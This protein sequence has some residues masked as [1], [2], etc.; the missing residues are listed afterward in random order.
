MWPLGFV[1]LFHFIKFR[2]LNF[3]SLNATW[4]LTGFLQLSFDLVAEALR[5]RH[6]AVM[7]SIDYTSLPTTT[8]LMAFCLEE[9]AYHGKVIKELEL[10]F[11]LSDSQ[12]FSTA[13][14]GTPF[15]SGPCQVCLPSA[16][17]QSTAHSSKNAGP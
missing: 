11:Q 6:D 5:S 12:C 7:A 3:H 8:A 2:G 9:A 15:L 16:L 14:G 1:C 4:T 17:Y 13:D 10:A